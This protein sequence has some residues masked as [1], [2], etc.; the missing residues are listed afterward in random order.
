MKKY[1]SFLQGSGLGI[2]MIILIGSA[3]FP[4]VTKT[5]ARMAQKQ[6]QNTQTKQNAELK[7]HSQTKA[8]TVVKIEKDLE[9]DCVKVSLKNNSDK[10]ITSYNVGIGTA[11]VITDLITEELDE[12]V[13]LYPGDIRE[14]KYALQSDI[15]LKGIT[16]LAVLF[17]DQSADGNPMYTKNLE[18]YRYGVKMALEQSLGS[19]K[20]MMKLSKT[21]VSQ[22]VL[23]FQPGK[24]SKEEETLPSFVKIGLH[25]TK[26]RIARNIYTMQQGLQKSSTLS[27]KVIVE[28]IPAYAQQLEKTI[29]R[30]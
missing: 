27:T 26:L 20:S 11:D 23:N 1:T 25:D 5:P 21:E 4:G 2:L 24:L 17:A 13:L 22:A 19:L 30:L 8:L 15:E 29:S 18:N 3:L 14:E 28:I 16:V 10:V 12:G 6:E 9:N 7:V